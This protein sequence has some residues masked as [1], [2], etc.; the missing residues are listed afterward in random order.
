MD[1]LARFRNDLPGGG[2][3]ERPAWGLPL[4]LSALCHFLLFAALVF[5]PAPKSRQSFSPP[6]ISVDLVSLDEPQGAGGCRRS[7]RKGCRAG[8]ESP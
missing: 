6:V 1:E 4:A 7:A 3:G 5:V 8:P 2:R